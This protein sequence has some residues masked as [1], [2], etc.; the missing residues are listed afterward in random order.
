MIQHNK[1]TG[2]HHQLLGREVERI[3]EVE[4]L[5]NTIQTLRLVQMCDNFEMFSADLV[6]W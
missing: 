1:S 5:H 3:S 2:G 6:K 4:Q